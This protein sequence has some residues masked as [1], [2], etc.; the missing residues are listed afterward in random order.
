MRLTAAT[1]KDQNQ[2]FC[3]NIPNVLWKVSTDVWFGAKKTGLQIFE[4]C[5]VYRW[6]WSEMRSLSCVRLFVTPWAVAHQT[7]QSMGFSRQEYWSGLPFPSPGDLPD[8][9]W[10]QVSCTTGRLFTIWVTRESLKWGDNSDKT[11][12]VECIWLS[13]KLAVPRK[14]N[15][16]NFEQNGAATWFMFLINCSRHAWNMGWEEGLILGRLI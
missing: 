8:P 2:V 9:D 13:S 15:P 4:T 7:P 3:E 10:T 16:R 12:K 5:W 14:Q 1:F 11:L 6:K